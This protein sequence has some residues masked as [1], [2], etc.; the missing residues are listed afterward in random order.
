MYLGRL[1][2]WNFLA[3]FMVCLVIFSLARLPAWLVRSFA[4]F[5]VVSFCYFAGSARCFSGSAWLGWGFVLWFG[6]LFFR[7]AVLGVLLL[8]FSL[9]LTRVV[10]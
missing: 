8:V 2:S 5:L 1:T 10:T 9:F 3:P 7:F 6:F 4:L